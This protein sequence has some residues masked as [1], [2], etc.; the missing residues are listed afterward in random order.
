MKKSTIV[1]ICIGAGSFL[2]SVACLISATILAARLGYRT[3]EAFPEE[4]G[5]W[6]TSEDGTRSWSWNDNVDFSDNDTSS[7]SRTNISLPGLHVRVNGEDVLVNLP[8]VDVNVSDEDVRVNLPGLS[9]NIDDD[10]GRAQVYFEQT[11]PSDS[12]PTPSGK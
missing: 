12:E 5:T 1:L 4:W 11:D 9:V 7:P 10:T 6:E 8:G 3:V 2:L